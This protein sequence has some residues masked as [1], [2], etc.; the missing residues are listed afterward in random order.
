[1][2]VAKEEQARGGTELFPESRAGVQQQAGQVQEEAGKEIDAETGVAG[3]DRRTH[4]A[5]T[6]H[7]QG[8]AGVAIPRLCREVR[9]ESA[10][11][12]SPYQGATAV[13]DQQTT[14][15]GQG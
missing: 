10:R 2:P 4:S 6:E 11:V 3:Q 12:R 13:T 1:M 15:E 7:L 5:G 9:Q 14:T 8:S